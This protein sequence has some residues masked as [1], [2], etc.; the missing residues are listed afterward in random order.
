MT[1]SHPTET[2]TT[3]RATLAELPPGWH[4]DDQGRL[5][6]EHTTVSGAGFFLCLAIV[7]FWF[8][9][10]ST[11]GGGSWAFAVALWVTGAGCLY[12]AVDEAAK[13]SRRLCY[14]PQSGVLSFNY[15]TGKQMQAPLGLSSVTGL[16][17]AHWTRSAKGTIHVYGVLAVCTDNRLINLGFRADDIGF[18][19]G[20]KARA[21]QW[22]TGLANLTGLP[23]VPLV[24]VWAPDTVPADQQQ[25]FK[26]KARWDL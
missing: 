2:L 21:E 6:I 17:L 10:V 20:A 5:V 8:A 9:L 24:E 13:R 11:F 14:D 25:A 19:A 1:H 7:C 4:R 12:V 23:L 26:R 15:T 22:A 3:P 18:R 16:A